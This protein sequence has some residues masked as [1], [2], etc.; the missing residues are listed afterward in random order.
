[1]WLLSYDMV[2]LNLLLLCNYGDFLFLPTGC[3]VVIASRKLDRLSKSAEEIK[4]NPH[5]HSKSD[6]AHIQCN[7]RKEEEVRL[8]SV[9][10]FV[11][12]VTLCSSMD[13]ECMHT[14]VCTGSKDAMK[15]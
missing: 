9:H 6:L 7:I 8:T 10:N 14:V 15:P 13:R 11:H 1:M 12:N 2:T 4:K 3:K 5:R